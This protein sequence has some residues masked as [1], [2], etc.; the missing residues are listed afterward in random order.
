MARKVLAWQERRRDAPVPA[1]LPLT[2]QGLGLAP[3]MILEVACGRI[4]ADVWA[5]GGSGVRRPR[6]RAGGCGG[7]RFA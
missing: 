4:L 5:A 7:A 1:E 2:R 3:I 6:S